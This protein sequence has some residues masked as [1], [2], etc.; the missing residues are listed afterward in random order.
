MNRTELKQIIKKAAI[1][2]VVNYFDKKVRAKK[3]KFQILD[4]LMP[5]E[6]AI[7]SIVGGL[8]TS[9]GTTLW[10]PLAKE[11]AKN[12]G[13][14]IV[15]SKLELPANMPGSLSSV[16]GIIIEARENNNGLYNAESSHEAIKFNCQQFIANPISKF[17]KAPRGYGVDIWLKKDGVNYFFDTKTVQPNVGNYHK[18]LSQVLNWYA[19]FYARY[20]TEKAEGRIVFPYN[21]HEEDFWQKTMG[22]G[23]P[24]EKAKEG[25][26]EDEFWDFLSGHKGT[27]ML[28]KESFKEIYDDGTLEDQ[29]DKVFDRHKGN[30]DVSPKQV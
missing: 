15:S 22:G 11:I 14:E 18:F 3:R 12:N 10:E 8:E 24:I 5:K 1:N 20:P 19:Y 27:F 26:V 13:F 29:L 30:I 28:I 6:R 23:K 25:W 16:L 7:R 17:Q 2:S 4:L 21:P 9:M